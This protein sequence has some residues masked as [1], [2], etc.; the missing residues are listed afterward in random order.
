VTASSTRLLGEFASALAAQYRLENE[1][2]AGGMATVF[3]AHDIKHGREV[4]IKILR[5]DIA[6]SLGAERFLSEIRTT[7][8]LQHPHILP[9]FDSGTAAGTLYYVMP[10][11]A[12]E[13]L[14]QR[15]TRVRQLSLDEALRI[16][17]E[18]A[19]ALAYAHSHG[20]IHR[21]IKPENL[22]L[23]DGHA[24]VADFGIARAISAAAGGDSRLTQTGSTLGTPAYMSP[25]QATGEEI[26][27]RSDM[28]SLACVMYEMLAGEPPF[29]GAT[30]EASLLLRFTRPPPHV[31]A[32]V[33]NVPGGVDAAIYRAMT[34]DPAG[35]FE[36]VARFLEAL[37]SHATLDIAPNA[38]SIAVLPFA[39][40]SGADDEFFSDG[41]TEEIINALAQLPGLRVAARTSCFAYKG[42]R[43]DLRL[44]GE[45]L[46]VSTVLE[47]SVRRAGGRLRITAQLID[48]AQ[49]YHIWSE[50]YDS[51]LTDVFSIQDAIASAIA[52]KLKV[53]LAGETPKIAKPQTPEFEAYEQFLKG[54]DASRRRGAALLH[55]VQAFEEAI[56]RDPRYAPALSGLAQSLT[57]LAFWGLTATSEIRSRA[58]EAASLAL[59]AD[60]SLPEAH[61]ATAL[62]AMLL[63]YDLEKAAKHWW[64]QR[65]PNADDRITRALFQACYIQGDVGA[66]VRDIDAVIRDDPQNAIAFAS[67]AVALS[68]HRRSDGAIESARRAIELQNDSLF[69]H[70]AFSH[71]LAIVGDFAGLA[72]GAPRIMAR[73][74]RHV[75]LL[76]MLG[77]AAGNAGERAAAQAVYAELEARSR[78]E[79]VQQ[80]VLAV[81]ALSAGLRDDALRH[82]HA[83]AADREALFAAVAL[84]WPPLD[85]LRGTR[86]YDEIL[87]SIGWQSVNR[88]GLAGAPVA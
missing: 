43:E 44:V 75:W 70:F 57:L 34:R 4:A 85:P 27:G 63:E 61:I 55:A 7:A 60:P 46:G 80:V 37:A 47:G 87:Q 41:I 48:V 9:L 49:G 79:F 20:V 2:G 74:G 59:A 3:L 53:T 26:D 14:R 35:R 23:A 51:E 31:S 50:R 11:V 29:A 33:R 76:M 64:P 54:R 71:T 73:F 82:L 5:P 72:P 45:R 86:E 40:M 19:D 58:I 67:R 30:T 83:S 69:S 84:Y 16:V 68:W 38:P 81:C 13:S 17:R 21:D 15:L 1:I 88:A 52:S 66:S 65:E 12:G 56:A 77:I 32:R 39:N 36:G 8:K 22:L 42:K 62:T 24:L 18:V 25:E 28:Y 10:Y 78:L 6:E